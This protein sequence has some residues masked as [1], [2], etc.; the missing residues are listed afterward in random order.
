MS[1]P[2]HGSVCVVTG[3]GSGIGRALCAALA[4]AGARAVCVVDL[5]EAA[6]RAVADGLRQRYNSTISNL[7]TL[8]LRANVGQEMDLRRVIN[9]AWARFGPVDHFFSNAGIPSNG[10]VEVSNDEWDRI[11]RVNCMAHVWAARHL[12]PRWREAG[13]GGSFVVTASAAGL[14]TQV[15]SMPYSVSK[16]A[17]V[18]MAEWLAIAHKAD[19]IFVHCLCPQAV[20]TG[21]LPG[22]SS[23]GDDEGDE[24]DGAA[25]G[26]A[27]VD[28]VLSPEAV[29][30]ET[31]RAIGE[32][33]FLVLPHKNVQKYWSRKV[34]DN[35]RWLR[36][37]RR[38]HEMYGGY[39]RYS[40][41]VSAAKL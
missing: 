36:G 9:A 24:A 17:A 22:G 41:N 1:I 8:V 32:G 10:G 15:G 39:L 29:A 26:P 2:I 4:R 31:L 7:E 3:G 14:L 5:N 20:K 23:D 33:R 35:D 37:M 19:N 11:W 16:H 30:E 18:A 13:R 28:G 12:L 25:A 6:A 34:A 27:G 21:M 38:M 40:P